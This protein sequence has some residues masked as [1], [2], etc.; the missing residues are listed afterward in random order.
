MFFFYLRLNKRLTK[1]SRSRWFVTPPR[2]LWRHCN[3]VIPIERFRMASRYDQPDA[4]YAW[5]ILVATFSLNFLAASGAVPMGIFLVEYLGYFKQSTAY[6]AMIASV[7]LAG[8]GLAGKTGII[9]VWITHA[10]FISNDILISHDIPGLTYRN[11]N[12]VPKF[13][14]GDFEMLF[15]FLEKMIAVSWCEYPCMARFY[16]MPPLAKAMNQWWHG[17]LT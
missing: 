10:L 2:S 12:N 1:Q 15:F 3:I 9:D 16:S 4:G 14:R 13:C 11:Q 17:S 5:V 6:T 7:H 8:W